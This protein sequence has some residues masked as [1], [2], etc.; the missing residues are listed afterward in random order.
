MADI[1]F[2]YSIGM[3]S[4]NDITENEILSICNWLENNLLFYSDPIPSLA[5]TTLNTIPPI[6][7]PI[8]VLRDF[9]PLDFNSLDFS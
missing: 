7:Q 1:V 4:G 9:N 5:N 3:I 2:A 6:E 8:V